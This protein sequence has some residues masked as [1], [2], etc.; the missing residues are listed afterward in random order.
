MYLLSYKVP[1]L[2]EILRGMLLQLVPGPDNTPPPPLLPSRGPL[3]KFRPGGAAL[4]TL[5]KRGG[6]GLPKITP[7]PLGRPASISPTPEEAERWATNYDWAPP[8]RGLE[9]SPPPPPPYT[10][11]PRGWDP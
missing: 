6:G 3:A 10:S 1:S 2:S 8:C 4:H 9:N 7:S 5:T 11:P